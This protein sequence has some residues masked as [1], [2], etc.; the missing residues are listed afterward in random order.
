VRLVATACAVAAALALAVAGVVPA[1]GA[2]P[3]KPPRG[4][5]LKCVAKRAK[6]ARPRACRRLAPSAA[7]AV[8]H[9]LATMARGAAQAAPTPAPDPAPAPGGD[10]P[11]APAP[12]PTTPAPPAPA[13]ARLG[14]VAREF[15]LVLSRSTLTAGAALVEL[16][17]RGE[18]A[19][20]LRIERIDGTGAATDVPLAEAGEVRSASA[21]LA[22]GDYKLYCA[23]PGHD[24]AGMHARLT[25]TP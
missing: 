24:A 10:A 21:Q 5:A 7:G 22:P 19:H 3:S 18:D 2:A 8:R 20:N 17:N 9:G 23:L 11:P 14:V 12:A 16:Q 13:P 1:A 25:V 6:P 15:S 4:V